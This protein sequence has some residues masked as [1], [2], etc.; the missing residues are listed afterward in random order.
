MLEPRTRKPRGVLYPKSEDQQF[1]LLR[2]NPS[3]ELQFYIDHFWI[4]EWD[5]MGGVYKQEIQSNPSV[6]LVFEKGKTW[7]W[8]V[9][10]GKFQRTLEDEGKVLGVR[11]RPGGF[12]PFYKS[13]VTEITDGVLAFDEVF[14]ADVKK[15]EDDILSPDDL[16]KSLE[17]V[18]QFFKNNLP[19]KD[20]WVERINDIIDLITKD[21]DLMS[22]EHLVEQLDMSKRSLQRLFKWYVGIQPTW[23]IKRFRL[24]EA[25][26]LIADNDNETV[27]PEIALELGYYDQ[28]HFIK[29]FKSVVGKT[30]TE[31]ARS[32]GK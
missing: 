5:A 15:L 4:L 13:S 14:D 10:T 22:V 11:F 31:Y 19:E 6:Q 3:E 27:W 16:E 1:Q 21:K 12:Y 26:A 18:E 8:G 30:P 24:H 7:I 28:A 2:F 9:I 20:E 23:V 25:A 17:C 29:D 32:V